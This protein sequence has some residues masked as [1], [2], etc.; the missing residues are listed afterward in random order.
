MGKSVAQLTSQ[1]EENIRQLL[2]EKKFFLIKDEA[3]V[4]KQKYIN[5]LVGS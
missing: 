4:D 1:K 3:E 2:R 5:I